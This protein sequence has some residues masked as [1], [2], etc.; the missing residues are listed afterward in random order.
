MGRVSKPP[1]Q[2]A[3]GKPAAQRRGGK[4][5][6]ALP[7]WKSHLGSYRMQTILL[8]ESPKDLDAAIDLLWTD[9]LRTLPHATPDGQSLVVPTEAVVYFS[10]KGLKFTAKPL[11]PLTSQS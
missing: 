3:D 2:Q 8:F 4:T 6:R 5:P 7:E 1:R 10:R 9:E 11:R